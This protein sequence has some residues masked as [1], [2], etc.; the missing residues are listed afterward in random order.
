MLRSPLGK[1]LCALVAVLLA[2]PALA[3]P[4][5]SRDSVIEDLVIANRILADRDV[6]DGYGHASVRDPNNPNQYLMAR[7]MAP[8]LVTKADIMTFDIDSNALNNDK[9]VAYLERFI[10]GEIYRQRPDVMAIVHCHTPEII[11]FGVTTVPLRPLYHM[12][13]FLSA[14]VPVY[15]IRD[16]RKADDKSMLVHNREL[17]KALAG[18]LGSKSAVLMR[19]HGAV[20]VGNSLAHAVGRS[21]YLKINAQQQAIAMTLSRKINYLQPGETSPPTVTE[22]GRDWEVWKKKVWDEHKH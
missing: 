22:F 16:F 11:P 3:A 13:D 9:R 1:V 10:H 20:L 4:P 7:S 19:G 8:E 21:V 2:L 5:V 6:V 14:G 17:G 18:V 15:E 12:T